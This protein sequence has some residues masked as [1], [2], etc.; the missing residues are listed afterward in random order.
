MNPTIFI[1]GD[2]VPMRRTVSLFQERQ[3]E[4]LFGAIR[5]R[6]C[7]SDLRIV[8]LEAPVADT[9][10]LRIR[11]SGPSLCCASTTLETLQMAG[12]NTVTL[13]NNHFRDYGDQGVQRTINQC[14]QLNINLIG[15]GNTVSEAR[16][17]LQITIK[18]KSITIINACET[19]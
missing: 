6:I 14:K 7:S 9:G 15:G 19:E 5:E 1:A 13:A 3:T 8:N 10:T 2:V 12:F 18:Q 16:R 11:K 4:T 17:P